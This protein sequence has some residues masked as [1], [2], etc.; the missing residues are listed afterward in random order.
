[1]MFRNLFWIVH[2]LGFAGDTLCCF[3]NMHS[4]RMRHYHLI[5]GRARST[6]PGILLNWAWYYPRWYKTQK[7]DFNLYKA[8]CYHPGTVQ[9]SQAHFFNHEDQ[10]LDLFPGSR[11]LTL[12]AQRRSNAVI[13]NRFAHYKLLDKRLYPSWYHKQQMNFPLRRPENKILADS[14]FDK[15]LTVGQYRAIAFM[16]SNGMILSDLDCDP[17]TFWH[18][19]PYLSLF[20]ENLNTSLINNSSW[21]PYYDDRRQHRI[22]IDRIADPETQS[23]DDDYYAEMCDLLNLV[24]DHDFYHTFWAYWFE[25]QPSIDYKPDLAWNF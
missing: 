8:L 21:I 15:G 18:R 11:T 25:N 6:V 22:L 3:L 2:Q 7:H 13:Y 16:D 24:P 12:T 10:L 23:L 9:F 14:L 20:Q 4:G 17:M 19:Q 1:M 5:K